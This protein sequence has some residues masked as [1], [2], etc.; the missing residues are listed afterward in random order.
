MLER[1]NNESRNEKQRN[2]SG[3]GDP[4]GELRERPETAI[5]LHEV[6]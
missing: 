6:S 1:S 5:A 2:A 4:K 3:H